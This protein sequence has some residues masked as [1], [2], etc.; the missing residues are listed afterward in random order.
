MKRKY[1]LIAASLIFCLGFG[2]VLGDEGS[3]TNTPKGILKLP[4]NVSVGLIGP[5]GQKLRLTE[6]N[7]Q[8]ELP[9]GK[10]QL[11]SWTLQRK[12]N[13]GRVWKLVGYSSSGH[14]LEI[15][16]EPFL[17]EIKPEPIT[18][19]ASVQY[20]DAYRFSIALKGP[21]NER[22]YF[23]RGN[24]R[25]EAPTLEITNSDKS[26]NVALNSSYG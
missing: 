22:M 17:L 19:S 20:R 5:Q 11:K 3:E 9:Q 6:E 12:D 25:A 2:N 16:E 23:Y 24:E 18:A 21:S 7:G 15:G 4:D 1:L 26:F 13:E 14:Y 8:V 10:Y